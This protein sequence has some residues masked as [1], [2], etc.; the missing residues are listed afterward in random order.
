MEKSIYTKPEQDTAL[1]ETIRR[2]LVR[3]QAVAKHFDCNPRTVLLWAE[4]GVIPCVRIG[5]A[6]R[7]DLEAVIG[8]A[9]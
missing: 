9:Q 1:A 6:V 4:K 7:F 8:S 5:G 2:P 3:A